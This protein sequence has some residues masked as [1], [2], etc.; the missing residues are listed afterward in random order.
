MIA[1]ALFDATAHFGPAVLA[2][3]GLP[4][5]IGDP[6]E[7]LA[8]RQR[9]EPLFRDWLAS[10]RDVLFGWTIARSPDSADRRAFA[11]TAVAIQR[12]R[13]PAEFLSW[14]YGAALHAA[15]RASAAGGLSESALAGLAPELRT[16][17]RLVSRGDLRTEEAAALLSQRLGYVRSRLLQTRLRT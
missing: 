15:Q 10:H 13:G 3:D 14:L 8:I 17:L 16:A 12:L 6:A 7:R 11:E 9:L 4:L 2:L 1:T 5:A